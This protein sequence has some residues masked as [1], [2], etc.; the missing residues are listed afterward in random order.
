M[1]KMSKEYL[2]F[3]SDVT[4]NTMKIINRTSETNNVD[5]TWDIIG[6]DFRSNEVI[7]KYG[8]EVYNMANHEVHG[9]RVR[10]KRLLRRNFEGATR[11]L[12]CLIHEF[13]SASPIINL[14][15]F[16]EGLKAKGIPSYIDYENNIFHYNARQIELKK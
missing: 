5:V 4:A 7:E 8:E 16:V 15:L 3:L 2:D 9:T 11:K 10:G 13:V 12:G 1:N 6:V 14:Q